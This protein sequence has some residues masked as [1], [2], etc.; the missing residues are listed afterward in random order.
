MEKENEM[1]EKRSF[2]LNTN[3]LP[4]TTSFA[5]GSLSRLEKIL[6]VKERLPTMSLKPSRLSGM[7]LLLAKDKSSCG[8]SS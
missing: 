5:F 2:K 3:Q 6:V 7:W 4:D 8:S 1:H